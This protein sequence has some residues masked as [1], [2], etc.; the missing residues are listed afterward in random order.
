MNP[1]PPCLMA[2]EPLTAPTYK[3]HILYTVSLKWLS[4]ILYDFKNFYI[5]SLWSHTKTLYLSFGTLLA[6]NI[7]FLFYAS[8]LLNLNLRVCV[9]S[10]QKAKLHLH[11]M[12]EEWSNAAK[13]PSA[14][15]SYME[16]PRLNVKKKHKKYVIQTGIKDD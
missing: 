15:V 12:R 1:G 13:Q 14:E 10:P 3:A 9:Y 2:T 7:L 8:S 4:H 11:I 16:G 5:S 6:Y